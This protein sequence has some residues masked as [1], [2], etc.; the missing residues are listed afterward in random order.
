ML[1]LKPHHENLLKG[2]GLALTAFFLFS[3]MSAAAKFLSDTHH[4]AE[5][6]FY[7][8]AIFLL[9]LLFYIRSKKNKNLFKTDKPKAVAFR[10]IVGSISLIVT[11]SAFAELP[12]ADATVL[13]FASSIITPVIVHF[14]LKEHIGIYRCVAI[15]IGL[16]GVFLMA[17]PTGAVNPIGVVFALSA[18]TMHAM[19]YSTLRYLK[20]EDSLT[21]TFYFILAGVLIPGIFFMPFVAAPILNPLELGLFLALG[22][23]GGCAQLCLANA[24]RHAPASLIAPLNYTGLIWATGFDIIIWKTI[25]GWPVFIGGGIIIASSLFIIYRENKNVQINKR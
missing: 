5:I 11:Y 18:A 14:A 4:V 12:M 25:P 3:V 22:V 24:H 19:M 23:S 8:N 17:A 13:L 20:T 16:S 21:V 15:L 2:V 6:A 1:D 9:P 10:A 7:R